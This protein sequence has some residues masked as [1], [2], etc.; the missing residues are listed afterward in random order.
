MSVTAKIKFHYF[1]DVRHCANSNA[2]LYT[3]LKCELWESSVEECNNLKVKIFCN[4]FCICALYK[5]YVLSGCHSVKY[6]KNLIFQFEVKF[7]RAHR[8]PFRP[9]IQ[10]PY[11]RKHRNQILDLELEWVVRDFMVTL[12]LLLSSD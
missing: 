9:L 8:F 10:C 2:K 6:N 12:I 4:I 1:H 7:L 11:Y 5:S 3:T